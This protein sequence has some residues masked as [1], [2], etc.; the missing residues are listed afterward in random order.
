M[1]KENMRAHVILPRDVVEAIDDLVGRRGRS[2]FFAEAAEEKLA[3]LQLASAARKAA[4]SLADLAVAG[5]ESSE[6]AVDW[7]R[8]SRR[9]DDERLP[10]LAEDN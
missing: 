4:G 9:A 8:A 5:W 7:V 1:S 6:S 2:K 3:R 10:H